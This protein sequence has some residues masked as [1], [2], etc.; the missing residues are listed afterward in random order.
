[1]IVGYVR[2]S[3]A[4]QDLNRQLKELENYKVDKIYQDKKS[5]TPFNR[6]NFNLMNSFLREHDVLVVDS[7]ERLGRNYQ[8]LT[9]YINELD[10]KN[11]RL[12]VLN[13]PL[14]REQYDDNISKLLR[15]LVIQ[16]LSWQSEAERTELKRKQ[17]QG[18]AIAKQRGHYKGK[19]RIYSATSKDKQKRLVVSML[20]D[21][22]FIS[23]I[24]RKVNITRQTVYRIKNNLHDS[25]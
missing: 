7:L 24:A 18:I 16:V 22:V 3:S 13:I 1:M 12:V 9:S 17:A 8:K 19:Q 20:Y 14:L 6:E 2:V 25:F 10:R 11:M 4:D 5:G 23:E 15:N 21:N